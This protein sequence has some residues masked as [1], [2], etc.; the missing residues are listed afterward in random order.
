MKKVSLDPTVLAQL[1]ELKEQV[2]L[3]DESG[4]AVGY[5]QP[6][7]DPAL[8]Q[9]VQVP[10]SEEELRRIEANLTGRPLAD[11]LADLEKSA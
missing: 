4:H 8:Y 10:V 6:V 2:V 11:I 7:A 9:E 1:R 3:C 5:F